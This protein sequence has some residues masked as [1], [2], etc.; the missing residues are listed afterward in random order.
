MSVIRRVISEILGSAFLL[1]K[2][3]LEHGLVNT[4]KI[5]DLDLK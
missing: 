3:S 2:Q 1:C 4:L 5:Q